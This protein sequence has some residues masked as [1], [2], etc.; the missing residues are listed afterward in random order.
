M[1]FVVSDPHGCLRELKILLRQW[2]PKKE[3]LIFLGDAIDR[4]IDSLG[5]IQYLMELEEK[6]GEKVIVMRGNHDAEFLAWLGSGEM[7]G[8]FYSTSQEE[9][10]K[11][12]Y[13]NRDMT[14]DTRQQR[15]EYILRNYR[16]EI[17]FMKSMRLFYETE[18]VLFVHA[19]IDFTIPDWRKAG[20]GTFLWIRNAFF[21]SEGTIDKRILFGH[22]PTK[23]L[24]DDRSNKVWVNYMGD[25]IGIDGGC[26]FGGQLNGIAL[27]EKGDIRAAYAVPFGSEQV[28]Y[29]AKGEIE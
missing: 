23:Y 12:F 9:T 13:V 28:I 22:T 1:Y 26:V 11:S 8:I 24:N 6:Y 14:R 21:E 5:V 18:H 7:A 10:I 16:K 2:D 19:G 4:G 3:T 20:E 15:A 17:R 27:N 25:K 29:Y